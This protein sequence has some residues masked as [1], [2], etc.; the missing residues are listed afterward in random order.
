MLKIVQGYMTQT[1]QEPITQAQFE[2]GI[3]ALRQE[4][5]NSAASST[6]EQTGRMPGESTNSFFINSAYNH[7]TG[8]Y[9]DQPFNYSGFPSGNLKLFPKNF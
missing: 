1:N 2:A 4:R 9:Q 6:S 5:L 8:Y 3:A 7:P